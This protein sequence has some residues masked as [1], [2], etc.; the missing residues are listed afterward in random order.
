MGEIHKTW[1]FFVNEEHKKITDYIKNVSGIIEEYNINSQ[2][3]P[4]FV[5]DKS[6]S[7]IC[8]LF[9][10]QITYIKKALQRVSSINCALLV[11]IKMLLYI[12]ACLARIINIDHVVF[13][14]HDLTSTNLWPDNINKIDKL[15]ADIS[16]KHPSRPLVFRSL[17]NVHNR[18]LIQSL[19][20]NNCLL[21]RFREI[22]H[23]DYNA[24]LTPKQKANIKCDFKLIEKNNYVAVIDAD[25]NEIS[26]SR[27]YQLYNNVYINKYSILNPQY[28]LLFFKTILQDST[29]GSI[30][31][32]KNITDAF[33]IYK[34][35]EITIQYPCIGY[36]L[37]I[38]RKVGLY[39][40]ISSMIHKCA[41][42][43]KLLINESSGVL[44][45]KKKRGGIQ[46][47]EYYA[48]YIKHLPFLKKVAWQLYLFFIKITRPFVEN[49]IIRKLSQ[50]EKN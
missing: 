41:I 39:R 42:Q 10:C 34:S 33:T 7:W 26:I 19:L 9:T 8:S 11:I 29:F 14:N 3:L 16:A 35:N 17:N 23:Y 18:Q 4:V 20:Q 24:P 22:T 38:E 30:I 46:T 15:I 48:I 50:F 49:V 1:P 6:T 5:N 27:L 43:K 21:L 40:Q 2:R 37:A 36:D 28:T 44:D 12:R 13:I 25:I 31:I 45:F 32:K 47:S